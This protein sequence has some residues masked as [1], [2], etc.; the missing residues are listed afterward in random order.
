MCSL[1]VQSFAAA[2]ITKELQYVFL[3]ACL[4]LETKKQCISLD[5]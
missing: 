4:A 5:S 2:F 1:A 3:H